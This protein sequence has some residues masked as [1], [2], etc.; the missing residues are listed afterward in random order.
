MKL[1]KTLTV[2]LT[3]AAFVTAPQVPV[4]AQDAETSAERQKVSFALKTDA[5][6]H[7]SKGYSGIANVTLRNG[8]QFTSQMRHPEL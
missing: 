5:L 6:S 7:G 2:A 8:P 4:L 3:N 1:S